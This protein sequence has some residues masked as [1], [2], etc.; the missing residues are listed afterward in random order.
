[1]CVCVCVPGQMA[2]YYCATCHL[3]EDSPTRPIY[4]CPDC[5]ICRVGRGL[6]HDFFHC[7]RCDICMAIGRR[8]GHRCVENALKTNC[9]ICQQYMFTSTRV[10]IFMVR[11]HTRTQPTESVSARARERERERESVGGVAHI[12]D[13]L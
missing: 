3:F 10:V 2:K 5:R 4:H 13:G 11:T 8:A 9:P 1:M 12:A 7:P 6:G